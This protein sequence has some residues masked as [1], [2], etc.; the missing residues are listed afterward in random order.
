[1]DN[2]IPDSD[3]P[4]VV[5]LDMPNSTVALALAVAYHGLACMSDSSVPANTVT[6]RN[7]AASFL[8]W[9]DAH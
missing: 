9:L 6:V 3:V 8:D 4:S 1:M 7:T 5:L 2:N